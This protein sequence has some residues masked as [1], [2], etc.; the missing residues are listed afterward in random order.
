MAGRSGDRREIVVVTKEPREYIQQLKQE[1]GRSNQEK[2][3]QRGGK[4]R[5]QPAK[6]EPK[7]KT[8]TKSCTDPD[9]GMMARPGKPN[10]FHFLAHMAVNPAHGVILSVVATPGNVN[11]HEACVECVAGAKERD[12]GTTEAAADAGGN[13]A[14]TQVTFPVSSS[15]TTHRP[16]HI[17]ALL[18]V[19]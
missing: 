9:A 18:G 11:D 10:G 17:A 15:R 4:K 8:E 13:P 2:R 6:E 16:I 19:P 3:E 12:P 14:R 7:G 1:A 5:G